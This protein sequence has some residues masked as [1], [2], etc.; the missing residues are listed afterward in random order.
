M[1]ISLCDR[2]TLRM[3]R[4]QEPCMAKSAAHRMVRAILGMY[5]VPNHPQK[6]LHP[7]QGSCKM[8]TSGLSCKAAWI[9]NLQTA[10]SPRI[11]LR[12]N[13]RSSKRLYRNQQ[14]NSD[15]KKRTHQDW[16]NNNADEIMMLLKENNWGLFWKD[17][18]AICL[19][20]RQVEKLAAKTA[21]TASI[22]AR[23]M[24]GGTSRMHTYICRH[25]LHQTV[26]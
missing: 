11:R 5:I 20:E 16:F 17:K 1:D 2:P 21:E 6:N 3:S 23:S 10:S 7:P 15:T 14:Q 26:I 9:P 24:V 13:V 25:T 12:K 4:Y 22:D 18:N 8:P 19:L